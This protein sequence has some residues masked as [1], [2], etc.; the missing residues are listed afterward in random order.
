MCGQLAAAGYYAVYLEYYSQTDDVTAFE[1]AKM[2]EF[3]PIWLGEIRAGI[4][5]MDQNPQIDPKR[6]A[7]MGFSLGSFL[8]LST[9]AT[10]PGKIAAIVEYYGGLPSALDAMVGNLPPTLIIHG[11]ADQLVP[12]AQAH[13]LDTMMT[14][15]KRPHEMHIYPGANHAF[16]FE[17]PV[18]YNAADAQD[19]W[20]RSLSFLAQYLAVQEAAK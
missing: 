3:F 4:D 6:I 10:D 5:A 2:K 11:D 16:N 19:A 18:W 8:S 17:I 9:G 13:A 15:A 14:D 1:P 20:Q 12:V 7:L